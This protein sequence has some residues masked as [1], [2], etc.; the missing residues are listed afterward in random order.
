[1]DVGQ[2]L[3]RMN[4]KTVN[5]MGVGGG[6]PE[7]TTADIAGALAFVPKGLGRAVL[8]AVYWPDGACRT[9]ELRNAVMGLVMP[10]LSRQL[11][12]LQDAELDLQLTQAAVQWPN[13]GITHEQQKA[14]E[15]ARRN[16]ESVRAKT[17]PRNTARHLPKIVTAIITEISGS[18]KCDT[19]NG[20]G[21]ILSDVGEF[22]VCPSCL[23]TG[24]DMRSDRR[25]AISMGC[26][27]SDY[28][29]RWK[30]VYEWIHEKISTA[31]YEATSAL[32]VALKR[33]VI[34]QKSV[35]LPTP[36]ISD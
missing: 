19:C 32:I 6:E 14:I 7:L 22:N 35:E 4:P 17:W 28:V 11:Y 18:M 15:Y 10:E 36:Y 13:R 26:D 30:K 12:R 33:E 5:Y 1:M 20:R 8:E 29:K 27:P 21:N 2:L 3:A 23:A 16:L 31:H 24:F 9:R 34:S 25:R